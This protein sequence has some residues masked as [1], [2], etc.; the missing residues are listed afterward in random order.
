V[1]LSAGELG[2]DLLM[3]SKKGAGFLEVN[4]VFTGVLFFFL[5]GLALNLVLSDTDI[6]EK[7]FNNL[8]EDMTEEMGTIAGSVISVIIGVG[9]FIFSL[10]GVSLISAVGVL[11]LWLNSFLALYSI[12]ITVFMVSWFITWIGNLIPFT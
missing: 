10:F 7:S 2:M 4:Y 1:E 8:L 5:F 3:K 6:E 12:F 9:S 11:P